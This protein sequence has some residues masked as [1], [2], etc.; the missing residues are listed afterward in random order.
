MNSMPPQNA[1][2]T[3]RKLSRWIATGLTMAA[4][5][6]GACTS[7]PPWPPAGMRSIPRHLSCDGVLN[8][9]TG[10]PTDAMCS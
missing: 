4:V 5:L 10:K 9:E 1:V 8:E 2:Q 7:L 3:H 6:A